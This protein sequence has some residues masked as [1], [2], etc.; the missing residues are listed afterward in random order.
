MPAS[1]SHTPVS[2]RRAKDACPIGAYP[3]GASIAIGAFDGVHLGHQ[4]VI[5]TMLRRA[6]S[7]GLAALVQTFDPLPKVAFGRGRPICSLSERIARL[8]AL[9]VDRVH[10]ADFTPDYAARP[11]E[12]F[13]DDL[14]E[15]GVREVYVG[16]DF[17]FHMTLT[18]RVADA[19]A[20][21]IA[22]ELEH[23]LGP[24]LREAV[25][26]DALALFVEPAPGRPFHVH[27]RHALCLPATAKA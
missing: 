16:E 5:G 23:A 1:L 13:L 27:S 2:A 6:R 10:V 11:A 26:L 8:Y 22:V 25:Q 4:A 19:E 3:S 9:G 7:Q 24:A 14:S 15:M 21:F 20:P 12:A 17:R 18:N